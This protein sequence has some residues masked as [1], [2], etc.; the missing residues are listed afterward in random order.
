MGGCKPRRISEATSQLIAD[1]AARRLHRPDPYVAR[2]PRTATPSA[3]WAGGLAQP[4]TIK[5]IAM[6]ALAVGGLV[7]IIDNLEGPWRHPVEALLLALLA[8]AFV[9]AAVGSPAHRFGWLMS[10]SVAAGLA[11]A[12]G[13]SFVSTASTAAVEETGSVVLPGIMLAFAWAWARTS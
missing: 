9:A 10:A 13:Y 4:A 5:A 7:H 12:T 3:G 2:P 6:V 11:F 8:V 1:K